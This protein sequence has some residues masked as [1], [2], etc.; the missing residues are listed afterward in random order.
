MNHLINEKILEVCKTLK[1]SI[2]DQNDKLIIILDN[3]LAWL[4]IVKTK[5]KHNQ[6]LIVISDTEEFSAFIHENGC[7]KMYIDINLDNE[8]GIDLAE[9][10][11]LGKY[12]GELFFVSE[13]VP[14]L[15]D[16]QRID[17][18]GANFVL[19]RDVLSR[20]IFPKGE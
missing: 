16:M 11:E 15:S 4:E 1:K 6:N 17:K 9:Q 3:C 2:D 5:C 18:L 12:F 7:R 19:K 14:T 13:Q 8:N 10:L 20:I